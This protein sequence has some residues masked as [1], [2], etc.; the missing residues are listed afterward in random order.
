[1]TRT[2]VRNRFATAL[3][4]AGALAVTGLATSATVVTTPG[5]LAGSIHWIKPGFQPGQ[6]ERPMCLT[7]IG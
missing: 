4:L 6:Q 5:T 1:M 7:C 3:L 2:A